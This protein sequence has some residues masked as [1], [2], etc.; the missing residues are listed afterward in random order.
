MD[1]QGTVIRALSWVLISLAVVIIAGGMIYDGL[2]AGEEPDLSALYF[3]G[4]A[5]AFTAM[6]LEHEA[7]RRSRKR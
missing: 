5:L 4:V 6:M 3:G 2:K 1:G 7:R